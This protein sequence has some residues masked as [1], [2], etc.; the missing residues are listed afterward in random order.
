MIKTRSHRNDIQFPCLSTGCGDDTCG[1][2]ALI[3]TKDRR[4][5]R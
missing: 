2:D 1:S 3:A 5:S 4:K